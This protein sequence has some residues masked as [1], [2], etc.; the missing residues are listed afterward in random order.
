MLMMHSHT[1]NSNWL[2]A[3]LISRTEVATNVISLRFSIPEYTP[4]IPGQYY[5]VRVTG[6]DGL[7]SDRSYSIVSAPHEM[8]DGQSIVEF[9]V[10]RIPDGVVSNALWKLNTGDTVQLRG[11][12]GTHFV[13]DGKSTVPVVFLAGGT[14]ITPFMSM[15]RHYMQ[16]SG[17]VSCPR[18]HLIL[19]A[20]T[21]E[22]I[23]YR[24][25]L[26]QIAAGNPNIVIII[27]LSQEESK[28]VRMH[29]G[30]ISPQLLTKTLGEKIDPQTIFYVCGHNKFVDGMLTILTS[31][32]VSPEGIQIERF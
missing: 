18:I 25:E 14:G 5:D 26:E 24:E 21:Y 20:K 17:D 11:P 7:I 28:D 9:G 10:Q 15:V 31:L 13:W 16:S 4:H 27:T 30:R 8:L 6:T 29:Y 12:F 23:P 19:S 22:T 32:E 2:K 1:R 3:T